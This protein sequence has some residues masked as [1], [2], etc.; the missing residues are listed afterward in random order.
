MKQA[1]CLH[2]YDLNTYLTIMYACI[3]KQN[4]VHT[5]YMYLLNYIVYIHVHV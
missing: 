5:L 4:R 2:L 1:H 3:L